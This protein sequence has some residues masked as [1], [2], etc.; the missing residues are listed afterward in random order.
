MT[1]N[2]VYVGGGLISPDKVLFNRVVELTRQKN[3]IMEDL[4][5]VKADAVYDETTNPKGLSKED[6][7]DIVAFAVKYAD[8]KYVKVI[9]TGK[10][11]VELEEQLVKS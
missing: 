9:E 2:K 5:Q 8:D 7:A 4:K 10:R 11:Y 6:V 3:I 1:G